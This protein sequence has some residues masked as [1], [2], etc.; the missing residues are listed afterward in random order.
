VL[1]GVFNEDNTTGGKLVFNRGDISEDVMVDGR[2]AFENGLPA[3]GDPAK[4]SENEWGRITSQQFLTPA[5]DNSP[6]ARENQDIGLDGLSSEEENSYFAGRFIDRLSVSPNALQQIVEDP[7]AD[8]FEYYLSENHDQNDIKILERY[9]RFN[10]MEDNTPIT[11]N[12][13]LP[14]TPSGSNVPDNEDLNND[15]TLNELESYYE[16]NVE[17]KPSDMQVG[18]NNIVDQVVHYEN[19]EEVKWFLF[20]IPIRQPDKSHGGISGYKSIRFIRTYLTDFQ[21][22]VVLRMAKFQFVGSQWRTFQESLFQRGFAE[23]PEP[24]NSNLTVG[25]VNIEENGQGSETQSP[26]V[27]PPGIERDR[28][29]TSTVERELNE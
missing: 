11:S 19:G 21:Q 28:D 12:T 3:D 17:L 23:V 26:Y 6:E 16:Y 4:A 14:Y 8:D 13:N 1:D 29:N 2:H 20:R 18:R 27:L 9:K 10:G 22:P 15:N 24:D 7:S 25:V 5:F